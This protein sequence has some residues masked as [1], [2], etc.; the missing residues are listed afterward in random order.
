[1]NI[2]VNRCF[3]AHDIGYFFIMAEMIRKIRRIKFPKWEVAWVI[4]LRV[5][6]FPK[7]LIMISAHDN[8]P[9]FG[10]AAKYYRGFYRETARDLASMAASSTKVFILEV[11]GRHAVG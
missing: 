6:A 7:R 4:R 5:L 1:V 11:M 8:C 2:V 3:A 10:S 9:G